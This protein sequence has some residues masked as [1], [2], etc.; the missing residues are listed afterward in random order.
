LIDVTAFNS[1]ILWREV[2]GNQKSKRKQ[3]L[4]RLGSELCG[5]EI[6]ESGNILIIAKGNQKP[7][8]DASAISGGRHRC[9]KQCCSGKILFGGC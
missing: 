1:F 5:G 7:V 2:N 8:V 9:H 3:F 4:K 6:D